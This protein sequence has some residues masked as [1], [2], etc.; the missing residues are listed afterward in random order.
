[1]FP[2]SQPR[3]P[4]RV[5]NVRLTEE[6]KDKVAKNFG[7]AGEF[8]RR[9][10]PKVVNRYRDEAESGAYLGL[11]KAVVEHNPKLSSIGTFAFVVMKSKAI[12]E[13]KWLQNNEKVANHSVEE[14]DILDKTCSP[15]DSMVF[16]EESG[17]ITDALNA[18]SI[19]NRDLLRLVYFNDIKQTDMSK[20]LG[21]TKQAVNARVKRALA[22]LHKKFVKLT[23]SA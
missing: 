10:K 17:F 23:N 20:D 6:Q 13:V 19:E 22:E 1:M 15:L 18:I 12:N 4:N 9:F 5:L 7:L 21:I 8:L 16:K 2:Q 14:Y 11:M 3:R